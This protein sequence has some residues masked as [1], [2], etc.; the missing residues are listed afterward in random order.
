MG[1]TCT[2]E[3]KQDRKD[4]NKGDN[5][6]KQSSNSEQSKIHSNHQSN[7]G[8][9]HNSHNSVHNNNSNYNNNVN[10]NIVHQEG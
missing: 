4:V 9:N 8:P 1:C 10:S 3:T 5:V 7:R 6:K 2:S